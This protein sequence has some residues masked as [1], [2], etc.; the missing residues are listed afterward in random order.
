MGR[1]GQKRS[2]TTFKALRTGPDDPIKIYVR[3]P[4]KPIQALL[5]REF[6]NG[7]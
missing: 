2:F 7:S 4:N 3:N 5:D 6:K 1:S